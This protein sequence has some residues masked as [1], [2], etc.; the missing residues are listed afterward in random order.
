MQ[1]S[2]ICYRCGYDHSAPYDRRFCRPG[3]ELN[4]RYLVGKLAGHNGE[5]AL[6][7]GYDNNLQT[8]VWL[9]EYFPPNLCVRN[10][11]TGEITP[12]EGCGAQYK[13][14]LSDYIDLCKELERLGQTEPIVPLETVVHAQGTVYAVYKYLEITQL[15]T[16][17]NSQEG[18]LSV[19]QAQE[20]FLP[21]CNAL[22][23]IHARGLIHRGISPY[24]VYM[25]EDDR[26]YLWNFCLGAART[27]GS[28]LEAELFN[29]YSAPEQYT[30][31]GWQGTWTDVYAVAALFYRTVS[32]FVP[33]KSTQIGPSRP[34]A[35]LDDL[36]DNVPENIADAVEEAMRPVS[37]MRMQE[38]TPFVMQLLRTEMSTTTIYDASMVNEVNKKMQENEREYEYAQ[39]SEESE[40]IKAQGGSKRYFFGVTLAAVVVLAVM[41]FIIT[42]VMFPEMYQSS[43]SDEDAS[44]S[45]GL[46]SSE[47]SDTSDDAGNYIMPTLVGKTL[48]E[49]Q[50]DPGYS[51]FTFVVKERYNE[52]DAGEIY[53]HE[54]VL[55][56]TITKDQ[57]VVL[58]VSKGPLMVIM[59]D[60]TGN[61]PEEVNEALEALVG[62]GEE[63]EDIVMTYTS[64]TRY[65]D[66]DVPAGT[67]TDSEPKA[68]EKFD[69]SSKN[70]CVFFKP[71]TSE[72]EKTP[73]KADI[74][75]DAD[76]DDPPKNR[77]DSQGDSNNRPKSWRDWILNQS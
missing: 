39:E 74:D 55:G 33:P 15:E 67:A 27:G 4:E 65:S 51:N 61:T 48:E 41:L 25:G 3:T 42:H 32:G 77:N 52:R 34:L 70:I 29:G 58:Y 73:D 11:L 50:S 45:D 9:R 49:V 13:A 60:L 26:L 63:Y 1:E 22:S 66:V 53:K 16:W 69:I 6:Y 2:S 12:R 31:N 28:E 8:R 24:T 54:P 47:E 21:L 36:V 7:L 30:S 68:G 44:Q 59:P 10:S 37:E 71:E 17:L 64:F 43:D 62:D 38:M 75:T 72:E 57:E 19:T 35:R 40:E 76:D 14:L 46:V 20:L 18:Q 5:S 56:D 23:N